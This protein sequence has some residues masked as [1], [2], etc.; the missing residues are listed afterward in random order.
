[1]GPE[2]TLDDCKKMLS[3]LSQLIGRL[4]KENNQQIKTTVSIT[5]GEPMLHPHFFE[6]VRLIRETSTFHYS[7]LSN[8]T[9]INQEA[10][11]FFKKYPPLTFQLSMEGTRNTHDSI[12]GKGDFD[13][14]SE[15]ASKLVKAG[16]KTM[17]SFTAHRDNFRQFEEVANTARELRVF[18]VWTDR[19][20]PYGNGARLS[21]MSSEETAEYIRII[22]RTKEDKR[23]A[24]SRTVVSADRALQF[25]AGGNIYSCSAGNSLLTLMPNGDVLPCRRMPKVVGNMHQNTLSE[26][27]H[28]H[29][30]LTKLRSPNSIEGCQQCRFHEKCNGGLKCL[31]YALR[32]NAFVKDVGCWLKSKNNSAL[33]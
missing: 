3:Q 2:A 17:I 33:E 31:S 4:E 24:R 9:F 7:V 18:K 6:I 11:N 26:I 28:S 13:R 15:T 29:P 20:I 23:Y 1:M 5:G 19:L 32:G 16:I 21:A 12:R 10:I 14:T 27:Y 8:G 25:F 22:K 30:F